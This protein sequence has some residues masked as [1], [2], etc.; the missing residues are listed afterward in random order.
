MLRLGSARLIKALFGLSKRA[1]AGISRR[2]LTGMEAIAAR[3]S[4]LRLGRLGESLASLGAFLIAFASL[5]AGVGM[6]Y[7]I[8]D[9][10]LLRMGPMVPGALPLEQ[11][12]GQD[13]QPLAHMV[14]AWLPAGFVAGLVLA[15]VTRL[16][17]AARTACLAGLSALTLLL[18]GALSDSIAVNDPLSPHIAPQLSRAG[19]WIAVGLFAAGSLT[20]AW[21]RSVIRAR[22]QEGAAAHSP[23]GATGFP[24]S[25][26]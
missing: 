14:I 25:R 21:F 24:A 22:E 12:A 15:S 7:L 13:N 2:K 16:G 8:R 19:T 18:A 5:F 3:R 20:A 9:E 10:S 11:L 23:G 4:R 1:S 17:A 26:T 6:L